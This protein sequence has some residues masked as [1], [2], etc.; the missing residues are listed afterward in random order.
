MV[1]TV[2]LAALVSQARA[3][4]LISQPA[5]LILVKHTIT[6]LADLGSLPLGSIVMDKEDDYWL[7]KDTDELDERTNLPVRWILLLNNM[8]QS[9]QHRRSHEYL[10]QQWGPLVY[11]PDKQN[12]GNLYDA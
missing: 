6:E 9:S 10:L 1:V 2:K 4:G 7:R 5:S 12:Q 8:D 11:D 3:A